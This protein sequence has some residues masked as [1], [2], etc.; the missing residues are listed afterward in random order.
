MI[1]RA[2]EADMPALVAMGQNFFAATGFADIVPFDDESFR[3]T[4]KHLLSGDSV[5]LVAES[6]GAVVG[7]VGALAYPFYFNR[8]H[9]TGQEIFW[10][11]EP[12]HRCGR[13]GMQMFAAL[14]TWAR[15]VGCKSFS[16]IAL[17]AVDAEK[18]G[19]IYQRCGYRASEHSYIKEL[20]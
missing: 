12:E 3:V 17:D 7:A 4:V 9:K 16:M 18:V 19:K 20:R 6:D 2:T 11:L 13:T 15:D 14:E 10:W 1:R 8:E 5:C